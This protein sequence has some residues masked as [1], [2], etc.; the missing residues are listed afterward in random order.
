M[1]AVRI[2]ETVGRNPAFNQRDYYRAQREGREY[3]VELFITYAVGSV[4]QGRDVVIQCTLP[5]PTMV[6]ADE[7]C[8]ATVLAR[9]H[10]PGMRDRLEKLEVMST[11]EV[12]EKLTPALKKYVQVLS[13][14][15]DGSPIAA[16]IKGEEELELREESGETNE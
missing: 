6:P 9:L 16:I 10:T 11:P 8:H 7:E 14:K 15:W 5:D 3:E 1:K 12:F 4:A 2:K 13:D